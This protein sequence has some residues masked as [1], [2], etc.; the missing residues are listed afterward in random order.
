[1]GAKTATEEL[2]EMQQ[3]PLFKKLLETVTAKGFFKGTEEGS[4]AYKERYRKMVVRFKQQLAKQKLR[5]ES[6]T[7]G[8]AAENEARTLPM[9]PPPPGASHRDAGGGGGIIG[10][11]TSDADTVEA[12]GTQE[13]VAAESDDPEVVSE[14]LK[15]KGNAL[16]KNKQYEAAVEAYTEAIQ[17]SPDGS[18]SHI[19]FANRAAARSYLK[20]H[21]GAVDDCEAAI[22]RNPDYAKAHSRLGGAHG[23]LND[24]NMAVKCY[25]R[26]LQLEPANETFASSL[27]HA[28][29]RAAVAEAAPGSSPGAY[30]NNA[31]SGGSGAA[32]LPGGGGMPGGMP[33]GLAD[34]MNS[35]GGGG[36]MA[37][38]LNNP[39]MMQMAQNMM[40]N[41]AM[42]QQ[43]Q[44]MMQ[45]PAMMQMAQNMM[46][47]MDPQAMQDAMS[48]FGGGAG[49]AVQDDNDAK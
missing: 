29:K 17:A 14:R 20:Q 26:A 4:P 24:W 2:A 7:G 40:Q 13:S 5:Q 27:R 6:A 3:N 38:L 44:Q 43:A 37:G 31:V 15:E 25:T 28:Q 46:G 18:K 30:G 35:A 12:G 49:G 45:N 41:P 32:G 39:A 19:Y 8:G 42:M 23:Q 21:Q 11:P 10:A 33:A 48:A 22:A 47:N 36:G 9:P 1:M 16:L 34:M